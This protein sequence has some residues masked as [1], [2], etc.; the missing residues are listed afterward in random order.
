VTLLLVGI[1]HRTAP[2]ALR[3]QLAIP[4]RDLA[5][6]LRVLRANSDLQEAV[7][8][9]TCNRVELYVTAQA[10][11]TAFPQLVDFLAFQSRLAPD[12]FQSRLYGLTDRE[13]AAHLFRVTAGMDS[14]VLG[15]SEITAQVKQA[16]LLAHA[17]GAT[18]PV[19][20]RIFQKALHS[21]KV[22]RARTRIAAGRAS[23]GSVVVELAHQLFGNRL[24]R[25]QV[26]LWGAGTAA[27]TTARHLISTGIGHLWIVN[28]TPAGSHD[29]A[30]LCQSGWLSWEQGLK[31][32]AHVDI[33]IVCTQ[34]PH[35]VI[36]QADVTAILPHRTS[37]PLVLIDLAVPRNVAPSVRGRPG[38]QLYDLDDLEAAAHTNLAVRTREL[39]Q[40]EAIIQAQVE[41]LL[42]HQRVSARAFGSRRRGDSL[43]R[44]R[45]PDAHLA[46]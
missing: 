22:I 4:P 17:E 14:M 16:Y 10:P 45:Q 43:E 46:R 28:R 41:H 32:L 40:C 19:L 12:A 34:A 36:D 6:A 5:R 3:E 11:S 18:G 35:Y 15:E 23:I 31:H 7:I 29:L 20:H 27:E 38:I 44:D 13:A 26:L 37:R 24:G 33:A 9:S 39:P 42:K 8:L 30:T 1:S 25:C 2:I 21:A